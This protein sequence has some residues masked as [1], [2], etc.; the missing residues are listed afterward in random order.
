MPLTTAQ[1]TT[2]KAHVIANADAAVQAAYAAGND[3]ELARL[4]NLPSAFIVW[5]PYTSKVAIFGAINW[6]NF[7]PLDPVPVA[8]VPATPTE[9]EKYALQQYTARAKVCQSSQFNIQTLLI[10][11]GDTLD[12]SISNIRNGVKDSLQ[13][14][15][16]GTAG[17][18][19]DAGWSTVKTAAT[20]AA[21][22]VESVFS[23]GT[24]TTGTPGTL[25]YIGEVSID[26]LGKM[27]SL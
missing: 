7:T 3:T 8:A 11:P 21:R 10:S 19:L 16:S 25:V 24:G 17:A 22:V 12:M 1:L 4:Y 9:G 26:D 6:K 2:L 13:N 5:E 20:R 27:R 18:L 14:L 15:P 23:T